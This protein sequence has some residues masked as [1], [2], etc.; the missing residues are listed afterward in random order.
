MGLLSL[1]VALY[2]TMYTSDGI[3]AVRMAKAKEMPSS[4]SSPT[5]DVSGGRHVNVLIVGGG[6]AG[7]QWGLLMK[8]DPSLSYAILERH[9]KAGEFWKK[10]PRGR[11]LISVNKRHVGEDKSSEFALRH[12]WNTLLN[13]PY[14]MKSFSKEYY[15]KA[16][17]LARYLQNVSS[18]VPNVRHLLSHTYPLAFDEFRSLTR[19]TF[20]E[21]RYISDET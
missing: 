16:D 19:S 8:D 6:V 2:A 21:C 10:F 4:P 13:E 20:T 11:K 12:D 18:Q 15:P 3:F 17:D 14:T 9:E 5:L 1:L 7:L